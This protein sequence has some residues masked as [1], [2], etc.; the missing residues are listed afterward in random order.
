MRQEFAKASNTINIFTS[1]R[2]LIN[3]GD[4]VHKIKAELASKL[5]D[6]DSL[7]LKV[8]RL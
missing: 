7:S 3:N 6:I 5:D 2:D 1:F 8:Q 4:D